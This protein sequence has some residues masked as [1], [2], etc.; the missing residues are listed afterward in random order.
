MKKTST[1]RTVLRRLRPYRGR[2]ALTLI[3]AM[4]QVAA[5][6]YVPIL[7]GR[8]I[9][10]IIAPG[11]VDFDAIASLLVTI[12]VVTGIGAL[13]FEEINMAGILHCIWPILYVGIFSS[14]VAYTL[15]IL[16]QKDSDPTVVT[17]LLSLESVFSVLAGAILLHD[18]M[19]GREYLGCVLMFA[20]VIL[21]QVPLKKRSNV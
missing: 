5:T 13:A 20:A 15:Q 14:G 9:D 6:L 18:T 21:A 11:Q 19:S 2:I 8:A 4:A 10:C 7:V 3:F 12:A 1:L 16:A 17:I